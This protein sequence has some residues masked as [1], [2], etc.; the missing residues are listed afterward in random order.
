MTDEEKLGGFG[1]SDVGKLFTKEGIKAKT[2]QT[3]AYE[4]AIELITGERRSIT[5]NAMQHGIYNEAEAY[6]LVVQPLF[7]ESVYQS[8]VSILISDIGE[9]FK[10]WA[11]P[12]VV[13]NKERATIDIK[14]PYTMLS[15]F[16]NVRK[17]PDVYISQNQMQML[18][19]G[20]SQGYVCIYLTSPITDDYGNKKEYNISINDRHTFIPIKSDKDYHDQ[21]ISR[22]EAFYDLRSIIYDTLI[23][24]KELSDAEYFE[25]ISQS[26]RCTKFKDKHNL[27]AWKGSVYKTETEGYVVIE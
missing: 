3:L 21:I 12:D 7:P 6:E 27:T 23:T 17:L 14:C 16:E 13:D 19:T 10:I 25:L 15:Y 8:D 20:H 4:K 9:R 11:S 26:D 1:A 2:A 18:A 24:A 5:T 22:A